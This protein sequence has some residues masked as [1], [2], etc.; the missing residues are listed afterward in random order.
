MV[1]YL[2][3]N[4]LTGYRITPIR[5]LKFSL[6]LTIIF[7]LIAFLVG[8]KGNLYQIHI[9]DE[10]TACVLLIS[11]FLFPSLLEE[12]FF[13]GILIPNT[14]KK[15]G[16]KAIL[17]FTLLSASLFTIWHPLNTLTIN[18]SAQ[19][20]FLN[21]YFLLI[22]FCLGIICSLSYIYS[23]SLW[24]PIIIHWLTTV[25]WVIFLGGRNLILE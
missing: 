2:K 18:P 11:L 12:S 22:V 8:Y 15:K 10:R 4:L 23:R 1:N 19:E 14:T 3:N 6:Y 20:F 5:K 16:Q 25:I 21:P 7:A 17:G 9:L 24:V 13:R